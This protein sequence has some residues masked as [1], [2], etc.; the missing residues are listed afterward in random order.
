MHL[1]QA[2]RLSLIVTIVAVLIAPQA[3][4]QSQKRKRP[5]LKDFGS[6]LKRLKWDPA[7]KTAFEGKQSTTA[8]ATS[9][10]DII[11]IEPN[12]VSSDVLAECFDS[13]ERN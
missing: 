4:A 13:C 5:K 10:E 1:R 2:S 12:L 8:S 6:S 11:R 7:T 3:I 9:Q